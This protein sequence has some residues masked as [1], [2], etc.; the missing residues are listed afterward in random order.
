MGRAFWRAEES[1]DVDRILEF[2]TDDAVWEGS[3]VTLTGREQIREYHARSAAAYPGLEVR[4]GRVHGD[5]DVAA[6]ERHARFTG[7][8]GEVVPLDGVNIM[9]RE[10]DKIGALTAYWRESWL[11]L[12]RGP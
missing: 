6:L 2:F 9:R 7:P 5:D 3:G 1:R 4:V 12:D 11:H 8:S 10:G